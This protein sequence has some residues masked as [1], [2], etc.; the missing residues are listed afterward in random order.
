MMR[1]LLYSPRNVLRYYAAEHV[2]HLQVNVWA[3]CGLEKLSSAYCTFV[4]Q[5]TITIVIDS[6]NDEWCPRLPTCVQAKA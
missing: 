6:A 4:T 3:V 2:T 5:T 1:V